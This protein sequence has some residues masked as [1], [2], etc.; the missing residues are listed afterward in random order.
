MQ[1]SRVPG[2]QYALAAAVV[3]RRYLAS[4]FC[5]LMY[6]YGEHRARARR[7]KDILPARD[8]T[9]LIQTYKPL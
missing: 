4:V 5:S 7:S 6:R 3:S 2:G 9:A 1:Q 8:E